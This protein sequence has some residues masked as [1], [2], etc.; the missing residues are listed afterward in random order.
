MTELTTYNNQEYRGASIRGVPFYVL[1]IGGTSGRRAVPHAY[2]KR[3]LGW[4]ED[5]GAILG[6]QKIEA[7]CL[8]DDYVSQLNALLEALNKAGASELVHPW[9]GRQRVQVGEVTHKLTTRTG[10]YAS[11][12]FDVYEA[13]QRL[14]PS[15][16]TSTS[17]E[18]KES[19]TAARDSNI[20]EFD[21]KFDTEGAP[22]YA[23]DSLLDTL[24]SYTDALMRTVLQLPDLPDALGDWL[25]AIDAFKYNLGTL[26]AYPGE[27]ARQATDLIYDVQDLVSTPPDALDVYTTVKSRIEGMQAYTEFDN[28]GVSQNPIDKK[29]K[30]NNALITQLYMSNIVTEQAVSLSDSLSAMVTEQDYSEFWSNSKGAA[31]R[32]ES[33]QKSID[34][35]ALSALDN[36]MPKSWRALRDVR[37]KL[38]RDVDERVILLPQVREVQP[39]TTVPVALLAYQQTG[40]TESR[41]TIVKRNKLRHPSFIQPDQRIEIAEVTTNV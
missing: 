39:I 29:T 33:V 11:V 13:G 25:D 16:Q 31:E 15:A 18:L 9:F 20:E 5:N 37:I 22:S 41:D 8:G 14:F 27:L 35:T 4:T 34:E 40:S 1:D 32:A 24:N 10:G 19:A 28:S 12:S 7:F 3:E 21:E 38:K 36:D 26:I 2:P 30:E 23:Q 17:D 6:K